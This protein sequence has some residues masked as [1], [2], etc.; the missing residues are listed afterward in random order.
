V[1]RTPAWLWSRAKR[2]RSEQNPKRLR[3][4]LT[5]FNHVGQYLQGYRFD[6]PN[7]FFFNAA[8]GHDAGKSGYGSEYPSVIFELNLQ[9]KR[10]DCHQLQP[11][12]T[13]FSFLTPKGLVFIAGSNTTVLQSSRNHS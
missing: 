12:F 13:D 3:D 7:G 2:S 4:F 8:I 1:R 11:Q 9:A 10:L 5:A 6:L